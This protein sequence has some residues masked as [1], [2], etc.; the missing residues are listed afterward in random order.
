[1]TND[2]VLE[3]ER[4]S[5]TYRIDD[6]EVNAVVDAALQ[7]HAGELVAIR[8]RSGSGKSTLL[9]VLGLL[10]RP[11]QGRLRIQER[12][13]LALDRAQAADLRAST[14]GFV[15]QS[16]NL[17][18][19]LTAAEN[20]A[21]AAGG[22]TRQARDLA[23]S[24]LER[25]GLGSRT[26]HLPSQ[27]SGGEQQRVALARALVNKPALI[28]ADEPTGN[29]DAEAEELVLSQLRAAVT[30]GCAVLVASHS[31]TVCGRAD[32]TLVMEKG[33]IIE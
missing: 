12:D 7:V 26:G 10:V 9:T 8:G 5:K 16:F 21:L 1:M 13:A 18:A 23:V 3:A 31:D 17:L 22:S 27:L 32:R 14:I 19:H 33:Q 15:F 4:L 11:D 2:I 28:L 6:T 20:V 29:L 24:L 30:E 25:A